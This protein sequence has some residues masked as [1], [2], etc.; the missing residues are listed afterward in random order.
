M[1]P[2][3]YQPDFTFRIVVV[4]WKRVDYDQA[5]LYTRLV[6]YRNFA[7]RNW[8]NVRRDKVWKREKGWY[9]FGHVSH[10]ILF[11]LIVSDLFNFSRMINLIK[12]VIK[13][14]FLYSPVVRII[15]F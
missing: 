7:T 13:F 9:I 3:S 5:R 1:A 10:L 2:V 4:G 15:F 14:S 12:F 6:Y 11:V 8:A